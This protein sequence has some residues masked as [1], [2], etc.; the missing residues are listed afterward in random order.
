MMELNF[1]A[2]CALS[3]V[4]AIKLQ[5]HLSKDEN[6]DHTHKEAGLLG[7]PSH[8]CI[9][10][11]ANGEACSQARQSHTEASPKVYKAPAKQYP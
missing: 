2:L 4:L 7:C 6:E 3:W 5:T 10:H 9:T 8:S 1:A 11:N